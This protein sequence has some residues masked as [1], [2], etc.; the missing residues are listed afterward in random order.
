M[1][2]TVCM[3]NKPLILNTIKN[4]L[5]IHKKDT[6]F[7]KEISSIFMNL[8]E[9]VIDEE[10]R[11]FCIDASVVIGEAVYDKPAGIT[12]EELVQQYEKLGK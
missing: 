9:F 12:F 2:Y 5:D 8:S 10:F 7:S 11:S 4:L 1:R 6:V 3:D